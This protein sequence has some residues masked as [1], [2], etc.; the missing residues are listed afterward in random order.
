MTAIAEALSKGAGSSNWSQAK[1]IYGRDPSDSLLSAERRAEVSKTVRENLEIEA[2]RARASG[3]QRSHVV[4][5]EKLAAVELG[6]L[7]SLSIDSP[8]GKG[9][10]KR[11]KA[12]AKAALKKAGGDSG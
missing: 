6:A 11:A 5:D 3:Q 7:P 12:R 10:G 9:Q 1:E 8:A 4:T 2:L